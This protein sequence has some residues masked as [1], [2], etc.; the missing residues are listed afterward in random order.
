MKLK[1]NYR[2]V[3]SIG[4]MVFPFLS[5]AQYTDT[6]LGHDGFMGPVKSAKITSYEAIMKEGQPTKGNSSNYQIRSYNNLGN[7]INV[8]DHA[9]DGTVTRTKQNTLDKEGKPLEKLDRMGDMI[10]KRETYNYDKPGNL[11]EKITYKGDGSIDRKVTNVFNKLNQLIE[12]SEYSNSFN[13][14]LLN[15]RKQLVY[16]KSGN[17]IKINYFGPEGENW[18]SEE[19]K[20]D[21]NGNV[22]EWVNLTETG[23]IKI[24]QT[25]IYDENNVLTSRKSFNADGKLT[26]EANLDSMGQPLTLIRYNKDGGIS[27]KSGNRYDEFGN[28]SAELRYGPD[29]AENV[30]AEYKYTYDEKNNWIQ[31]TAYQNGQAIFIIEREITYY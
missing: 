1:A 25:Y 7:L 23:E 3:L 26:N 13:E 24:R 12:S 15:E 4:M 28:N 17:N 5:I 20:F 14:L 30:Y 18:G 29:G 31:Q 21:N 2:C 10:I 6:E 16:D 9:A 11:I 8:S 27:R 19:R 22:I